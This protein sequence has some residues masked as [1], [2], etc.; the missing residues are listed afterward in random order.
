VHQAA[1]T[2]PQNGVFELNSI[3]TVA[4]S[5]RERIIGSVIARYLLKWA[6]SRWA[7]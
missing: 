4:V 5:T 3:G 2:E 6:D 1:Q 7:A